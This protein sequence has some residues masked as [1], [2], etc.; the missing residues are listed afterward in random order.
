MKAESFNHS[1]L[2]TQHKFS[3]DVGSHS[4][5]TEE[6]VKSGP[7]SQESEEMIFRVHSNNAYTEQLIQSNEIDELF[8][9]LKRTSD[10]KPK[11]KKK[12]AKKVEDSESSTIVDSS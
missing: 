6:E 4:N 8:N 7:S 11:K 9:N 2:V 3:I 12:V 1:S 5:H 10:I